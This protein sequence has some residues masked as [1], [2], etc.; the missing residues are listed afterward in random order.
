MTHIV[1]DASSTDALWP[2]LVDAILEEGG[3]LDAFI[4]GLDDAEAASALRLNPPSTE[5]I[6]AL[7]GAVGRLLTPRGQ[8]G[9]ARARLQALALRGGAASVLHAWIKAHLLAQGA[10][11][12]A[13]RVDHPL[14]EAVTA[15]LLP[16]SPDVAL[17]LR[18]RLAAG[19]PVTLLYQRPQGEEIPEEIAEEI[20]E[21]V[22]E[23]VSE[24]VAEEI[25]EEVAEEIA[26]AVAEVVSEAV[27]EEITEVVAEEITEAVA[28]EITEVVAEEIA[29][30]VAEEITEVVAEEIA[31]AEEAEEAEEEDEDIKALVRA[32]EDSEAE[33]ADEVEILPTPQAVLDFAQGDFH[34]RMILERSP[35]VSAWREAYVI[36]P[37]DTLAQQPDAIERW[38]SGVERAVLARHAVARVE[39]DV[40]GYTLLMTSVTSRDPKRQ[41]HMH[42]QTVALAVPPFTRLPLL[43][44]GRA[45]TRAWMDRLLKREGIQIFSFEATYPRRR[46]PRAEAEAL[47]FCRARLRDIAAEAPVAI[48]LDAEMKGR[49]E[50]IAAELVAQVEGAEMPR[51]ADREGHPWMSYA[52]ALASALRPSRSGE[53]ATLR[54]R[55]LQH[56]QLIQLPLK[57]Q[58][59]AEASAI[60]EAAAD[61]DLETLLALMRRPPA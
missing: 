16:L 50:A 3:D 43:S 31:E 11:H 40:E 28:E 21:E 7:R 48:Y 33:E 18:R 20:T 1:S 56:P 59:I 26:E 34:A 10:S 30:V 53:E 27:A 29:E 57:A 12:E 4:T 37:S 52:V 39:A 61:P 42:R 25:T 51:L 36:F 47:R 9:A 35:I 19:Q 32:L 58:A 38:T 6:E 22:A 49:G 17:D 41:G 8:K 55:L 15:Q 60:F 46:A 2:R 14:A 45:P 54:G 44:G 5:E 13:R 24:A 23:V